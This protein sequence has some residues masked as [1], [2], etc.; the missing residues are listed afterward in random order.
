M[1][2]PILRAVASLIVITGLI[3][4]L[5]KS[6]SSGGVVA[7][8]LAKTGGGAPARLAGKR[9]KNTGL[10]LPFSLPNWGR[11]DQPAPVMTVAARQILIGRTGVAVVDIDGQRLVLGV[12]ETQVSLITTLTTPSQDDPTPDAEGAD[13]MPSPDAAGLDFDQILRG[14]LQQ[15]L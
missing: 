12:S 1:L 5:G 3:L 2:E 14:S 4:W 15:H 8:L 7:R 10:Q 9:A 11:R 13:D 6:A